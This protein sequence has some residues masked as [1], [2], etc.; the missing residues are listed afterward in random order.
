MIIWGDV[1][2]S[3]QLQFAHPN[4]SSTFDAD[5]ALAATPRKRM[6]EE[7]AADRIPVLGMH[8]AFPGAG[9]VVPR[10]DAYELVAL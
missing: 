8:L 2:V 9:M 6:F 4:W 10:G 1:V 5:P 3:P 7:V